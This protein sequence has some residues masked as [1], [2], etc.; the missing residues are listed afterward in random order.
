MKLNKQV[1]TH[2]KNVFYGGNWTSVNVKEA[3]EDVNVREATTK[4]F[5]LNTI[6]ALVFHINYY[7]DAVLDVMRGLPLTASDK[8]SFDAPEIQS[9]KQWRELVHDTLKNADLFADEINKMND[10]KIH[11]D[12]A[13]PKYGNYYSNLAGIIEHTHYHLGQIVII[14]KIIRQL[15]NQKNEDF[16]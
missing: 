9:D 16:I 10:E 13:D 6:A 5:H 8:F 11:G 14:K 2:F 1:A 15:Y 7:V 3:L 4:I 12:F